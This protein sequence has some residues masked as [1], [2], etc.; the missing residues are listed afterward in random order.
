MTMTTGFDCDENGKED[1]PGNEDKMQAQTGEPRLV[2]VHARLTAL[3]AP[4]DSFA[5]CSGA[6]E[7]DRRHRSRN[8]T[9]TWIPE[10][11]DRYFARPLQ[12][13]SYHMN[14]T[15]TGEGRLHHRPDLHRPG[16]HQLTALL[17]VEHLP[18]HRHLRLGHRH[19]ARQHR[20]HH[21]H[22]APPHL[23]HRQLGA[24]HRHDH[25]RTQLH[26]HPG[27]PRRQLRR[28][29]HLHPLRRHHARVIRTGSRGSRA[30]PR[31]AG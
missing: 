14:H 1:A 15:P 16:R 5:Y 27:Q 30:L 24:G 22:P 23:P 4:G 28:R 20:R 31:P 3:T 26:P 29:R 18:R 11:F 21:H 7:L 19:P 25:R 8:T 17:V 2:Q 9:K 6:V 13:H 10:F 12:M